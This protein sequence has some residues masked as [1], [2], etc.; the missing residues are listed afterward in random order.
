MIKNWFAVRFSNPLIYAIG[1]VSVFI[2]LQ[3]ASY[4]SLPS[5]ADQSII[6]ENGLGI[7]FSDPLTFAI[8]LVPAFI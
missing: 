5:I 8:G 6:E 1:L 7:W 3:M 4:W 2:L